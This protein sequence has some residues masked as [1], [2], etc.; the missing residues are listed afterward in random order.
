MTE[1]FKNMDNSFIKQMMK[2]QT[3]MDMKDEDIERMKSMM[4]PEMLQS[5][6]GMDM[7]QFQNAGAFNQAKNSQQQQPGTTPTAMPTNFSDMA[8]MAS[9]LSGDT[10]KNMM[11]MLQ[12]NPEMLKTMAS[13]LGENH[14]L[15]K[16][17]QNK[18]PEELRRMIGWMQ[19]AVGVFG[20]FSPVIKVVKSYWQLIL[21]VLIG[22]ILY[23]I[24]S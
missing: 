14:P 7:S 9:G 19:K 6:A 13:M 16:M 20:F 15:A 12:Q 8:G 3:G 11:A 1:A 21:G 18:S 5:F 4:T 24:F 22:Y 17:I 23:R 10:I 2:Q